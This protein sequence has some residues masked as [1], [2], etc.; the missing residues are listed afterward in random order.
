MKP[1]TILKAVSKHTG[2]TIEEME[3]KSRET[4]IM[5]AVNLHFYLCKYFHYRLSKSL[6]YAAKLINRKSYT[7]YNGHSRIQGFIDTDIA[8]EMQ[9][10]RLKK[11]LLPETYKIKCNPCKAVFLTV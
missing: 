10:I 4:D 6:V 3:S 2:I 5:K 8:F 9:V 11:K 1:E 7:L